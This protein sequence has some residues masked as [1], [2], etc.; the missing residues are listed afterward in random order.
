[1]VADA[2]WLA[3]AAVAPERRTAARANVWKK[4]WEKD[5]GLASETREAVQLVGQA[6]ILNYANLS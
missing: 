1:M 5:T 2:V 4:R 3:D 6:Q